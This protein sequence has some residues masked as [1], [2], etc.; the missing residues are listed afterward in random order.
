MER[1]KRRSWSFAGARRGR[2]HTHHS[3]SQQLVGFTAIELIPTKV[4]V[5]AWISWNLD[6]FE[7]KF[8]EILMNLKHKFY[9]IFRKLGYFRWNSVKKS[10][11]R[12]KFKKEFQIL[13]EFLKNVKEVLKI[14]AEIKNKKMCK[15]WIRVDTY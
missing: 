6:E 7:A 10:R 1:R 13:R 9:E 14:Y 11:F 15:N 5:K 3:D 8:Y 12:E 2:S 4:E